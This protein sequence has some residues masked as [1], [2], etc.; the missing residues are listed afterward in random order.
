M[1]TRLNEHPV[2]T[3]ARKML[4]EG[5]IEEAEA[6]LACKDQ[7]DSLADMVEELSKMDN[8]QLPKLIEKI[9]G[10]Y[11]QEQA[12]AYQQTASAVFSE[13]LNVVKEKKSALE[14]AVLVLTGDAQSVPGNKTQMDFPEDGEE[15][16]IPDDGDDLDGE[17]EPSA[18]S[19]APPSP[20]GRAPRLPAAE[21]RK[22]NKSLAEAK[23]VALHNALKETNE[24]K[25]P[26][27]A[28]RLAEELRRVATQAI[29][30]A[31]K[32]VKI[33]NDAK[34]INDKKTSKG[35]LKKV[36]EGKSG[37]T[38][39]AKISNACSCPLNS[40]NCKKRTKDG[41]VCSDCERNHVGKKQTKK[42]TKK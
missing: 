29:K 10:T 13:L 26:L 38:S 33:K 12:E 7:V 27:R 41:E 11:G 1:K 39:R 24:K 15:A 21:S 9:R 8:D 42:P 37:A 5:N 40:C 35:M 2:K 32:D 14:Q 23:I 25:F 30:E 19:K 22:F 18:G 4:R 6:S 28:K 17:F 20:L 34:A 3:Y 31:A 36:E 16:P